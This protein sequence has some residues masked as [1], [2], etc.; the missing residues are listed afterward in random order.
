M[1][2]VVHLH[3]IKA[4]LNLLRIGRWVLSDLH[5]TFQ[6][7]LRCLIFDTSTSDDSTGNPGSRVTRHNGIL[8]ATEAFI[9]RIF[10]H[11]DRSA[12]EIFETNVVKN[13]RQTFFGCVI[14][15]AEVAR[16]SFALCQRFA[17]CSRR[18]SMSCGLHGPMFTQRS[19][20]FAQIARFVNVKP[21][22]AGRTFFDGNVDLNTA[23]NLRK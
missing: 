12:L 3:K 17:R 23:V 19:A 10:M 4:H 2:D 6:F 15:V 7:I 9:V 16:V 18:A 22:I 20:A 11:N 1:D 14:N 13:L 8:K 5:F 21:M